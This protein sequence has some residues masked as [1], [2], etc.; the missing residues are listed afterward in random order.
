LG[1]RMQRRNSLLSQSL[2]SERS[3]TSSMQEGSTP[4]GGGGKAKSRGGGSDYYSEKNSQRSSPAPAK[5]SALRGQQ[6]QCAPP[7]G[8]NTPSRACTPTPSERQPASE[9]FSASKAT[10]K[11][12]GRQNLPDST[13]RSD[14]CRQNADFQMDRVSDGSPSRAS[15]MASSRRPSMQQPR[16][17]EGRT[18]YRDHFNNS[19]NY[20]CLGRSPPDSMDSPGPVA[21]EQCA[22]FRFVPATPSR[23]SS[24]RSSRDIRQAKPFNFDCRSPKSE[25]S[26]QQ[27]SSPAPYISTPSEQRSNMTPRART[28]PASGSHARQQEQREQQNRWQRSSQASTPGARSER[29]SERFS[30]AARTPTKRRP[31][32]WEEDQQSAA[33]DPPRASTPGSRSTPGLRRHQSQ[34]DSAE[35]DSRTERSA[36]PR[37]SATGHTPTKRRPAPWEQEQQMS[38]PRRASVPGARRCVWQAESMASESRAERSSVASSRRGGGCSSAEGGA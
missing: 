19:D 24:A 35:S 22:Q 28:P 12:S 25:L 3:E 26:S 9:A 6:F 14:Y 4:R 17:F 20:K 7:S 36:T 5:K 15:S 18:D 30:E 2:R 31:A 37:S 8:E 11:N 13:S 33:S 1:R 23:A 38:D 10:R 32:P 27:L 34:A 21:V 29:G 16:I